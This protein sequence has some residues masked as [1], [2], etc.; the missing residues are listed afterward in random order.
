MSPPSAVQHRRVVVIG[1]Q[2]VLGSL[3]V[4]AFAS[5]AWHVLAGGRRPE[6][7]P[8]FRHVDLDQPETVAAAIRDTDVVITVV[9]DR[10]ITA[11]RMVIDRGGTLI[12][13]SAM[14]AEAGQ[15][16]RQQTDGPRGTVVMNA[17][18]APEVA[19]FSM[20]EASPTCI[21]DFCAT[22]KRNPCNDAP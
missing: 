9:P 16:L 6:D 18:I 15:R 2:G 4:K 8:D 11:E 3:L 19:P 21:Q 17:G 20:T 5:E 10:G 13:V 7:H 22:R 14:L 1:S 12:N